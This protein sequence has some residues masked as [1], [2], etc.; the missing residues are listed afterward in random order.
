MKLFFCKYLF[1]FIANFSSFLPKC[2]HERIFFFRMK[3][4]LLFEEKL[5]RFLMKLF[6]L[7]KIDENTEK[8]LLF[9]KQEIF[10]PHLNFQICENKENN[11]EKKHKS[12]RRK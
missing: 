7:I 9:K 4:K 8:K 11:R 2:F 10:L 12:C 5:L 6:S 3:Q 1:Y